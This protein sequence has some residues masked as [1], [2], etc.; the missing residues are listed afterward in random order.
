MLYRE[1]LGQASAQAMRRYGTKVF[2]IELLNEYSRYL[3]GKIHRNYKLYN[4]YRFTFLHQKI[5][6]WWAEQMFR[7]ISS[8]FFLLTSTYNI[9]PKLST[10]CKFT[11]ILIID[12]STQ[13]PYM[14]IHNCSNMC[15]W[16]FTKIHSSLWLWYNKF[17]IKILSNIYMHFQDVF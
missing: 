3:I 4:N 13:S 17:V 2:Y 10:S 8:S 5:K 11:C 15:A 16:L 12:I 7:E 9:L 1:K 6:Q 14:I